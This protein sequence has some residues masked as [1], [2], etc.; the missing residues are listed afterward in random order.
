MTLLR[1][2]LILV[3]VFASGVLAGI[4]LERW[5]FHPPM[6]GLV[7]VK[8]PPLVNGVPLMLK[9]FGL[10]PEQEAR[11]RAVKD[12]WQPR[13]DSL[14]QGLFPGLRQIQSGM[15]QEMMCVLTPAQDSAYLAWR[16]QMRFNIAEGEAQL[17]LVREGRCP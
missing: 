5:Q 2:V 17:S 1:P 7:T 9:R 3:A 6:E 14:M 10:S 8:S 12:R 13:A 15:F 11:M 16:R 4:A